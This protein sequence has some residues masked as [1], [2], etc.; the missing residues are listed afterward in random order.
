MTEA[1]WIELAEQLV[2][3]FALLGLAAFAAY[4]WRTR[5]SFAIAVV[6]V[7][8]TMCGLFM[9]AAFL[10]MLTPNWPLMTIAV[11]AAVALLLLVHPKAAP[12]S[13]WSRLRR[14]L[15]AVIAGSLLWAA[16]GV[17]ALAVQAAGLDTPVTRALGYALI[18]IYSPSV[19][20]GIAAQQAGWLHTSAG[21][22]QPLSIAVPLGWLQSV[23][24]AYWV[25]L[26]A[27]VLVEVGSDPEEEVGS[28]QEPCEPIV[29]AVQ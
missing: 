20:P 6:T 10:A 25:A 16:I 14:V 21:D 8:G 5:E 24:M 7:L 17:A 23:L 13:D 12:R 2:I 3:A 29:E 15:V 11:L 9:S 19:L 18:A 26:F 22:V 4:L 1:Q 27:G 28:E